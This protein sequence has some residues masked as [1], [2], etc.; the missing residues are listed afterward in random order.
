MIK[1]SARANDLL[2]EYSQDHDEYS[3]AYAVFEG[4]QVLGRV[5]LRRGD[6]AAAKRHLLDSAR[7]SESLPSIFD[8]GTTLAKELLEKG[9]KTVVIE[10]L[11]LCAGSH[12]D[13]GDRFRDWEDEIKKGHMPFR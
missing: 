3:R 11:H 9:Q 2:R 12:K 13:Q 8:P 10:Y 4:N 6:I 1:A 7:A 5:A